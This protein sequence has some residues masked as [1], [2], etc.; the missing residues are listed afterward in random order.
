MIAIFRVVWIYKLQ[1]L[2]LQ[3]IR[4][5]P[6]IWHLR[7]SITTRVQ[8]LCYQDLMILLLDK[9]VTG[10]KTTGQ[11]ADIHE[12]LF[13]EHLGNAFENSVVELFDIE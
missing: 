9:A 12:F 13:V 2:W 7:S 3:T 4:A 11:E 5:R 8:E 1:E 6:E 10:L